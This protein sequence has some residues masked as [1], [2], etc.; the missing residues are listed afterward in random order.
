MVIVP[1]HE[2]C[3]KNNCEKYQPIS[4]TSHPAK[5]LPRIRLNLIKAVTGP[6]ISHHLDTFCPGRSTTDHICL[7]RQL[8][9]KYIEFGKEFLQISFDFK[10]AF[11]LY[12]K[13]GYEIF[14]H[15]MVFPKT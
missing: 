8:G 9:E 5:I 14:W 2:K 10:L 13:T 12:G 7:V 6:I 15:T 3:P 11:L 4:L 1:L